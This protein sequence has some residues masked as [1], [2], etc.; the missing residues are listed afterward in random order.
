M[1]NNITT[2]K[3]V[4]IVLKGA[5]STTSGVIRGFVKDVNDYVNY[6]IVKNSIYEYIIKF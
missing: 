4:A 3:K 1:K 6:P 2:K 5:V